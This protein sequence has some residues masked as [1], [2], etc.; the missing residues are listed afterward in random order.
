MW[1]HTTRLHN[2]QLILWW[3]LFVISENDYIIEAQLEDQIT[4]TYR[5]DTDMRFDTT[6]KPNDRSF[7][8]DFDRDLDK[9]D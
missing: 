9:P 6:S 5:G 1:T 4:V 2:V 7:N 8:K 3:N